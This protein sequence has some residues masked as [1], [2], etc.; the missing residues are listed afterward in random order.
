MFV[1]KGARDAPLTVVCG[2]NVI[3]FRFEVFFDEFA[4]PNVIVD[5]E[6]SFHRGNSTSAHSL[7]AVKKCQ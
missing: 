5:H 3:A 2:F 7:C 1:G 6:H 4:Q